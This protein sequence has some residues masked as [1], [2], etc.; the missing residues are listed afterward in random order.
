MPKKPKHIKKKHNNGERKEK[1]KV[2]ELH[3]NFETLR[4]R[5]D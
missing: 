1:K 3:S 5:G 4:E 2:R